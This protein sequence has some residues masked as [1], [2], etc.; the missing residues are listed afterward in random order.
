MAAAALRLL[1]VLLALGASSVVRAQDCVGQPD[2]TP[3]ADDG[4][5]CNG[6]ETC[7]AGLCIHEGDPCVAGAECQDACDENTHACV[8]PFGVPCTD[9][10]NQ[11][12]FDR[13]DG[14]GTCIHP[15]NTEP[16][17]DGVFCNGA[18][19]CGGGVCNHSGDPCVGGPACADTCDETAGSC[20]SPPGTPC[21]AD[22]NPCTDDVCD[23]AGGCGVANTASC[24]D[25]LF[26]TGVDTCGGGIC[27]HGGDPCAGGAECAA[28]CNEVT[29]SC[30]APP[31]TPCTADGNPCTDDVCNGAG[32]CGVVNTASC[33]DGVFC[34]GV[35]TCSGGV[36]N[37][38]GDPCVG[39]AE[40]AATCN[41]VTHSCLAPPGTPCTA[42]GNPCTDDVCND[43]GNCGVA[44][45]AP[46]DDGL[47]CNGADTCSAGACT[48]V[49]DP[50]AAHPQCATVCNEAAATCTDVGTP[51][52]DGDA[53]TSD[54]CDAVA[55]MCT[56]VALPGST[57][58]DD[59]DAC[60]TDDHCGAGGCGGIAVPGCCTDDASCDDGVPCTD[61]HCT[62][63]V[64][65]HVAR[66]DRCAPTTDCL[67]VACLPDRPGADADGCVAR[68]AADD[69]FCTEDG[70][71]CTMDACL[72]GACRHEDDG[73]GAFCPRLDAPF[74]TARDVAAQAG[75]LRTALAVLATCADG[76][77]PACGSATTDPARTRLMELVDQVHGQA[78]AA[79]LALGGRIAPAGA[80]EPTRDPLLR[81]RLADG[82]VADAPAALRGFLATLRQS[83]K[84]GLVTRG[85][86]KARMTDGKKV[87]RDA[88]KLR[89]Q[90]RKILVR[91]QTFVR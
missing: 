14:G 54:A 9:D 91:R 7:Q 11:C 53:C 76:A 60:T 25:G 78:E 1:V 69:S 3:C 87:L 23:G 4:L 90:L 84:R 72:A 61:D 13:C 59:G 52:D 49:G 37:H 67:A 82:L 70:D 79:V 10:G 63:H 12:T 58:C 81:A 75:R 41:E 45:T 65:T 73:S 68:T 35:D 80:A 29:H 33:D 86:R 47:F 34:N 74:A 55:G 64:C 26:C 30:L 24:D 38:A 83:R 36:C 40:C 16:C 18:D 50:C 48:H 20:A 71:P 27:N 88:R 28:T 39:G 19:T 66:D 5:F 17:D 42:D 46:C 89:R 44:N 8:T 43:A 56:H 51:C 57:P 31:G 15:F 62:V 77:G 85:F 6:V 2:G 32:T 22:G 21:A